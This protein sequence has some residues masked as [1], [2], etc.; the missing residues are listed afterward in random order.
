MDEKELVRAA[1]NG[2]LCEVCGGVHVPDV[3]TAILMSAAEEKL[4]KE[5]PQCDCE[6]ELCRPFREELEAFVAEEEQ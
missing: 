4:K 2:A 1:E 6:C 3:D 5:I